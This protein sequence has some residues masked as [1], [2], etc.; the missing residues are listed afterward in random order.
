MKKKGFKTMAVSAVAGCLLLSLSITAFA[1]SGSG[2]ETYKDAFKST[3]LTENVTVSTQIEVTDNGTIILS[4]ESIKKLDE[5]SSSSKTSITVGEIS[6]EYESSV[7]N[8]NYVVNTDGKYYTVNKS[9]EKFG[10]DHR[11]KLTSSNTIK[12]AEM[13]TDTLVGD[14]KNQF[15]KDG[16]TISVNLEGAQIPELA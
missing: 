8:G 13:L 10:R 15:V 6:K 14:V 16:E 2:Y 4:G 3:V 9:D 1:T 12:L 5:K 7:N 11:E